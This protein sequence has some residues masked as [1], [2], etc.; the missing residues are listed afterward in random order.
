MKQKL[1]FEEWKRVVNALV[2]SKMNFHADDLPDCPYHEWYE[3]GM[4]PK[5]AAN[6]AIRNANE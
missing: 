6:K 4:A 5:V 2:E 3:S 1:T